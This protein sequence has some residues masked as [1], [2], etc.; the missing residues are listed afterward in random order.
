MLSLLAE[1]AQGHLGEGIARRG[2]F[3]DIAFKGAPEDVLVELRFP[4]KEPFQEERVPV[5]FKLLIKRVG[6][7]PKVWFEQVSKAAPGSSHPLFLMHRDNNGCMFRS[8]KTGMREDIEEGKAL[9]SDSSSQFFRFEIKTN[10]RH[11][12]SSCVSFKSGSCTGI[13][14]STRRPRLDSLP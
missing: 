2:G 1:A 3:E 6:S 4:S 8:I 12:T 9:E 11:L 13:S 7:N 5:T 10:I 14:M